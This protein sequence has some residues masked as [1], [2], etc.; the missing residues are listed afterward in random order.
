MTKRIAHANDAC[1][2]VPNVKLIHGA[3]VWLE[4]AKGMLGYA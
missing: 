3:S 4:M 1:L 2:D